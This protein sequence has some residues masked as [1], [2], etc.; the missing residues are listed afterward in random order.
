MNSHGFLIQTSVRSSVRVFVCLLLDQATGTVKNGI[1]SPWV[2]GAVFVTPP[3]WWH[4]HHNES[5]EAA[6]VLPM[7]DAGLLTYQRALDIRFA[8]APA[9]PAAPAAETAASSSSLSTN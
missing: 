9:A 3:G 2:T 6:W 4:S 7:Q 1:K 5:G 8:E